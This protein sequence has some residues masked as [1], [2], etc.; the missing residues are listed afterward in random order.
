MVAVLKIAC[1]DEKLRFPSQ[2]SKEGL[3]FFG[4]SERQAEGKWTAEELLNHPFVSRNSTRTNKRQEP[5]CFPA[6]IFGFG[7]YDSESGNA[8]AHRSKN[9]CSRSLCCCG[10]RNKTIRRK[11]ADSELA[12]SDIWLLLDPVLPV[13][14]WT[15]S[16]HLEKDVDLGE[17]VD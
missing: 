11:E 2:F 14:I 17:N 15:R 8:D 1:S 16:F 13:E 4:H 12:S 7:I 5:A 6:S 9:A 3:R 10:E